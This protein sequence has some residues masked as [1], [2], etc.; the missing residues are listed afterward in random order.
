MSEFNLDA[1]GIPVPID[2]DPANI[3]WKYDISREKEFPELK[4]QLDLLWHSIDRGFLG[5]QAKQSP[6]YIKLK[7]IKDKYPKG[8]ERRPYHNPVG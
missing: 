5:E 8:S 2:F 6:F 4:E 3:V 1:N 7:E